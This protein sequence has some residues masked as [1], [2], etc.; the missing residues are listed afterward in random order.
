M[1]KFGVEKAVQA[2]GG[3]SALARALG[4]SQPAI[5]SWKRIPAERVLAIESITGISRSE[6][7]P[8]LYPQQDT[9]QSVAREQMTETDPL[10]EARAREYELIGA[11]IW[12]APTRSTLEIVGE[13]RG[14]ASGLGMAHM[15]LAEAARLA[16]PETLRDDFFRLFIGVGRAELLPYASYYL[17]GFLHEKPLAAVREDLMRLGLAKAE[18]AGEPEDHIA[19]LFDVMAALLRGEVATDGLDAETFF[20]RHILPWAP[21]FF[22]DLEVQESSRFYQ[23]VGRLGRLFVAIEDEAYG[24]SS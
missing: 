9:V 24:L 19:I 20:R 17:T 11:L 8:D 4:I 22:A 6:L 14:D 18:R 10:D 15:E 21:R 13:I 1:A 16:E 23:I 5:S 7:R 3:A 12:R 2:A